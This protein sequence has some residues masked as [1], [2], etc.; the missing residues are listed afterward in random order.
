MRVWGLYSSYV[1]LYEPWELI[2]LF[3]SQDL[4]ETVKAELI[5]KRSAPHGGAYIWHEDPDGDDFFDDL[6]VRPLE[7]RGLP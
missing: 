6:H 2:D 1:A 5:G 7:V 3:A 4:A